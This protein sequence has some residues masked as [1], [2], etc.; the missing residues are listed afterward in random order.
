MLNGSV[1]AQW[2]TAKKDW[3]E[4]KKK[5]KM[6][7]QNPKPIPSFEGSEAKSFEN[8]GM[9]DKDMDA[10]RCILYLHG[11]QALLFCPTYT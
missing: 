1:D 11:G 5:Y 3:L 4:A 2:I 6:Q 10:M 8:E 9:Y 7:S